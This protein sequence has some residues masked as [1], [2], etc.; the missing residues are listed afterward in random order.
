[1]KSEME[2]KL[3]A[4][5]IDLHADI[6]KMS[7]EFA[8]DQLHYVIDYPYDESLSNEELQALLSMDLSDAAKSGLAKLFIDHCSILISHFLFQ[9]EGEADPSSLKAGEWKGLHLNEPEDTKESVS[10]GYYSLP[11]LFDDANDIYRKKRIDD[12]R[13]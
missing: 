6:K 8:K 2:R 4:A 13:N 7:G 10:R 11:D 3:I 1:M 12:P 9:L 5:F